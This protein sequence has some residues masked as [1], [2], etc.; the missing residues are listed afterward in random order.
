MALDCCTRK[1]SKGGF[2]HEGRFATLK[3]VISHYN[4]HFSLG[5]IDKQA[6]ELVEYLK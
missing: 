3:D 6:G 1:G 2:Y 4:K 5:L